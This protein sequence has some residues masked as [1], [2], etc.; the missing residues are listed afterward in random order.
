MMILRRSADRG[1]AVHG[2]LDS[3]H[4]FS[5]ANYYDPDWMGFG[6]L[7]VIN[8]DRIEGSKGFDPHH[9][10]DMEIL[11][12]VLSGAL[13]H[14]DSLGN[15]SVIEPN[16]IQYM[17]AGSGITHSEFN[18]TPSPVHLL[19]IW[20]EPNIYGAPPTY[21]EQT[22]K[23]IPS[24][25]LDL[26]VSGDG[27]HQSVPI[28]QDADLYRGL[29]TKDASV[30]FTTKPHHTQWIQVI[31]GDLLVQNTLLSQG[32]ACGISKEKAFSLTARTDV[33]FLLFEF[34][35]STPERR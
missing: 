32:D 30:E 7:R 23:P 31:H 15:G 10:S 12:Y 9:H 19:Q 6:P 22:L 29:F 20:I 11:T 35:E 13:E 1:H 25:T 27:R 3:Y 8:E 4:S 21:Q 33:H 26:I 18:P 14:R 28:R 16:K 24:N 5:F 2:W 34:S 17:S